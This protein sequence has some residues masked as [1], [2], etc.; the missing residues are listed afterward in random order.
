MDYLSFVAQGKFK[1]WLIPEVSDKGPPI[2]WDMEPS[3][4]IPSRMVRRAVSPHYALLV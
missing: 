3:I 1:A 2:H 4:N